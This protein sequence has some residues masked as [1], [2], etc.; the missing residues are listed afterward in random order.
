[1][2]DILNTLRIILPKSSMEHKY[3]LLLG[4]LTA[5][6]CSLNFLTPKMIDY[7]LYGLTL[8]ATVGSLFYCLT[9][10]ITDLISE[11]YGRAKALK[12]VF[13]MLLAQG[14]VII[15]TIV[16]VKVPDSGVNTQA[17]NEMYGIIFLG[18]M[19]IMLGSFIDVTVVQLYDVYAFGFW[20]RLFRGKWLIARN[21]L[22]TLMS[23]FLDQ[24][25]F[26]YLGLFLFTHVGQGIA[27]SIG[28]STVAMYWSIVGA[29][30]VVKATIAIVDTP[31]VYLGR[32]WVKASPDYAPDETW[33]ESTTVGFFK[34]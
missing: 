33:R 26:T 25:L 6:L 9:F 24:C 14:L 18:S 5:L 19:G 11:C 31:L 10:P 23:Q 3:Y 29:G 16:A 20:K 34:F 7:H 15:M 12:A 30:Y 28:I 21:N 4:L 32:R 27:E 13:I 2:K 8:I 1:M 17:F 22:S